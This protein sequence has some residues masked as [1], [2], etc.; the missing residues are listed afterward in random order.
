MLTL[1]PVSKWNMIKLF[2]FFFNSR[3]LLMGF[4]YCA[5]EKKFRVLC[6][7]ERFEVFLQTEAKKSG[8]GKSAL[9]AEVE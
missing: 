7:P 8:W 2:F 4:Y 6:K 9:L 5:S 1:S 3:H